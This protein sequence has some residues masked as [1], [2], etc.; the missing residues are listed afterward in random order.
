MSAPPRALAIVWTFC[1]LLA[2]GA[3]LFLIL[4]FLPPMQ[5]AVPGLFARG[6]STVALQVFCGLAL[7]GVVGLWLVRHRVQGL[8]VG[9]QGEIDAA[10]DH[11]LPDPGDTPGAR[12]LGRSLLGFSLVL[13]AIAVG[14]AFFDPHQYFALI[15]E[16][17]L[18]EY[19]SAVLWLL[20]ALAMLVSM[21]L[22]PPRSRP[23]IA[24][25]ALLAAF[26][27]VCGGEEVSW[28]QRIFGRESGEFF[29]RV[30]KQNETNLHNIGSISIF[31][32]LFFLFSLAFF[33]LRPWWTRR[34]RGLRNWLL[35]QRAPWLSEWAQR[36]YVVGLSVFVVVGLRFMTLGF[37]P[38]TR[39]GWYNQM[40]DE[41]FEFFAALAFFS[42]AV[43]DL[44]WR[45]RTR[46][47]RT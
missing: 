1:G 32:N 46:A 47:S 20:A 15:D 26:F 6:M 2:L 29:G 42:F 31:S 7:L 8:V 36:V 22:A 33:V 25:Y 38:F 24:G 40:D 19:A 13:A 23:M 5:E 37:S 45:A 30:N 10:V 39:N 12:T 43:L 3:V 21:I 4:S 44:L 14:L 17:G 28:G 16:D 11:E 35:L 18:V 27:F 9:L 34:S 41:I